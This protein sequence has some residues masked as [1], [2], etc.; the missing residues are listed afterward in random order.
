MRAVRI[1]QV[2]GDVDLLRVEPLDQ[3]ADDPH[4]FLAD[5]LL[6]DRAG[7]IERQI[8]KVQILFLAAG[9]D[10]AGLGFAPADQRLD[11]QHLGRVGLA[12]RSC[13]AATGP[14]SASI[15]CDLSVSM[16]NMPV[17]FGHQVGHAAGVVVEHGDVAAGHVGH[18]NFVLVF[19][20]PDQRA[21]HADHVVVGMRAE[22]D[23]PLAARCRPDDS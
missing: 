10:G 18:V 22:A 11:R 3:L 21:A 17:V 5:R 1:G 6:G 9:H 8:E 15:S 19:D 14:P 20:Q 7:A 23:D 4:V 13:A 12:R 2:A 16:P